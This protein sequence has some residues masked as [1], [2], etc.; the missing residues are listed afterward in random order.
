M[1]L[2][3]VE[4]I[5]ANKTFPDTAVETALIET[6]IS[7]VLLSDHFAWKIKKPVSFEFVDFFSLEKRHEACRREILLNSRFSKDLYLGLAPVREHNG[8]IIYRKRPRKAHRLGREDE[9][10]QCLTSNGQYAPGRKRQTKT[11]HSV[12]TKH[13]RSPSPTA[14]AAEHTRPLFDPG[15]GN[16]PFQ[17]CSRH[18]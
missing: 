6:H 12:G 9:E 13:R 17:Y 1:N 16:S 5:A 11:Y 4:H 15:K 2:H 3:Q 14:Q 8:S 7:W 18:G 10:A